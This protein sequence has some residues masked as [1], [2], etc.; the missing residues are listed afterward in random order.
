MFKHFVLVFVCVLNL[1]TLFLCFFFLFFTEYALNAE[2]ASLLESYTNNALLALARYT[3]Q[4]SHWLRFGSLLLALRQLSL[5]RY[6]CTLTDVF[7]TIVKDILK[8][9]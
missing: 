4:Q 2:Y 5:R 6:E 9:L 3:A 8:T 7:R 1:K